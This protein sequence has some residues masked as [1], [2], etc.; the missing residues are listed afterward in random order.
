M[1]CKINRMLNLV[2][3]AFVGAFAAHSLYHFINH[4]ARPQ[5]YIVDSAPWYA[6]ILA[7]GL[8]SAL[9]VILLLLAKWV[10]LRIR[11]KMSA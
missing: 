5:Q 10:L 11:R 8:I 1:L 2:I 9:I 3:I 4:L 7:N 6:S